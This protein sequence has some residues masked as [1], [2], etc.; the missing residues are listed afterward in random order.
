[1]DMDNVEQ[2]IAELKM[3]GYCCAQIVL[4]VAG[5]EPQGKENPDL[6]QS[7]RGLCYGLYSQHACGALSGGVCAL[8][9]Y[10]FD[11]ET[12]RD[13]SVEL[14]DWFEAHFGGADC[15][16]LIGLGG[17]PG[18]VCRDAI[19]LTTEKCLEILQDNDRI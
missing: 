6:L 3:Q 7:I 17:T 2:R 11:K 1:M 18:P 12:L 9:L 5:L 19:L 8:A 15:V 4:S 10:D 14:V 16:D 13:L